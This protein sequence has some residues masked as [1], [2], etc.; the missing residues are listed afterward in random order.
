M[1]Y[2]LE[3]KHFN[4][5]GLNGTIVR[6]PNYISN[7]HWMLHRS[8]VMN[9]DMFFD[10]DIK[11]YL[12]DIRELDDSVME[13][14]QRGCPDKRWVKT[15][16]EYHNK[17]TKNIEDEE[18]Y[19]RYSAHAFKHIGTWNGVREQQVEDGQILFINSIYV[20][21]FHIDTH[22]YANDTRSPVRIGK[23]D[24]SFIVMPMRIDKVPEFLKDILDGLTQLNIENHDI[25]S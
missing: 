17:G 22:V 12:R 4:A 8:K 9:F 21:L 16:W 2:L 23:T 5:D 25:L 19:D 14:I 6:S 10:K 3:R 15:N 18:Y 24:S 20:K 11:E 7:G 13:G 1:K